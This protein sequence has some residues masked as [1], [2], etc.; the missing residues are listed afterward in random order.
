MERIDNNIYD[1]LHTYKYKN[2]IQS[3]FHDIVNNNNNNTFD[4]WTLE[5][6][7][8]KLRNDLNNINE[9]EKDINN[10]NEMELDNN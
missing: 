3:Q 8:H 5:G 10:I 4:E 2:G 9:E 6:I 7:K 1:T